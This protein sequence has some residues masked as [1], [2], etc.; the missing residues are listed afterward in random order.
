[1]VTEPTT[2]TDAGAAAALQHAD[3]HAL[4]LLR[5]APPIDEAS[6]ASAARM[7]KRRMK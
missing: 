3:L 2:E 7:R 5:M 1:L 4:H 6:V